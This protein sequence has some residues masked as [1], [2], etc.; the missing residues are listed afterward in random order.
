MRLTV[1]RKGLNESRRPGMLSYFVWKPQSS[2]KHPAR[3]ISGVC[4]YWLSV[5]TSG[6]LAGF[7]RGTVK[8]FL[9]FM[10]WT[11]LWGRGTKNVPTKNV[12]LSLANSKLNCCTFKP[13]D[14]LVPANSLLPVGGRIHA[15]T[16]FHPLLSHFCGSLRT[17]RSYIAN[18]KPWSSETLDHQHIRLESAWPTLDQIDN[19]IAR[20][21]SKKD[22]TYQRLSDDMFQSESIYL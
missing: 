11:V 2:M 1:W 16:L 13:F 20:C 6:W 17:P 21:S 22:F 5:L 14:H 4:G 18:F 9:V 15:P 3:P 12:P 7:S 19:S 8:R 10:A